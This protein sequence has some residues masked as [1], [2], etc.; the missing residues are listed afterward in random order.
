MQ[1]EEDIKRRLSYFLDRQKKAKILNDYKS[2]FSY[3]ELVKVL[4]WVLGGKEQ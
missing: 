3:K 4:K 1:T 2:Y